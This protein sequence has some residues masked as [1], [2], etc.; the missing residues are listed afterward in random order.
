MCYFIVNDEEVGTRSEIRHI[1]ICNGGFFAP[2]TTEDEAA[3]ISKQLYPADLKLDLNLYRVKLRYRPFFE[4]R[5]IRAN[6][7]GLY[8]SW[9]P[10]IP[11]I[12]RE[13]KQ[14]ALLL[15]EVERVQQDFGEGIS[16]KITQK[17]EKDDDNVIYLNLKADRIRSRA[18]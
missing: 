8:T 16:D 5:A 9:E 13:E 10:K 11:G 18:A 1:F 4:S 7:Y 6:G 17:S 15:N 2:T 14:R 12:E 3:A